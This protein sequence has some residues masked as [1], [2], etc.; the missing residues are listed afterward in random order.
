[1][2][3]R[4]SSMC[5]H[6]TNNLCEATMR[7]YKDHILGRVKAHNLVALIQFSAHDLN[8]Y[9]VDRLR[10]FSYSHS[11]R[12]RYN[13][14][15]EK[16][17]AKTKYIQS[18]D[19]IEHLGNRRFKVRRISTVIHANFGHLDHVTIFLYIIILF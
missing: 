2:A 14:M 8:N 3:W 19:Q 1:M 16:D 17:I 12:Q 15:L 5:G 11:Q 10:V 6:S 9:Y 18:P 4:D 7:I 13:L